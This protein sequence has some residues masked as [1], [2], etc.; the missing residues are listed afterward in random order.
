[1]TEYNFYTNKGCSHGR[2]KFG[3][4][5]TPKDAL[6][7]ARFGIQNDI[8]MDEL[9]SEEFDQAYMRYMREFLGY[10]EIKINE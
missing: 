3:V 4:V 2:N 7:F 6:Q 5:I 10:K 1:M 9:N 8:P